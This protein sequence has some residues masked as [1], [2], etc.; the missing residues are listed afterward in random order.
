M[1]GR[2]LPWPPPYALSLKEVTATH[3]GHG[4]AYLNLRVTD[5][6]E[7]LDHLTGHMDSSPDSATP[8]LCIYTD[9]MTKK[10]KMR[11]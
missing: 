1:T 11:W 5:L 4:R 10:N 8:L 7:G 6:Q 9:K 3:P 2:A